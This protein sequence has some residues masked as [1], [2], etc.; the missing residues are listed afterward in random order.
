MAHQHFEDSASNEPHKPQAAPTP[1]PTQPGEHARIIQAKLVL[2]PCMALP[3]AHRPHPQAPP[4]G[5]VR[6]GDRQVRC[7]H[8]AQRS[9]LTTPACWL[10]VLFCANI[11]MGDCV[12][13]K[14]EAKWCVHT[15]RHFHKL[16]TKDENTGPRRTSP[17]HP[18]RP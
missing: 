7:A 3:T 17:P 10:D 8:G 18:A 11:Y 15:T 2:L 16:L 6:A 5:G 14:P 9:P 1:T 13:M 4:P 12:M